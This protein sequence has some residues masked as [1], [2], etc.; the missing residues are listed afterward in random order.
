MSEGENSNERHELGGISCACLRIHEF[1]PMWSKFVY[2]EEYRGGGNIKNCSL[3]VG[4]GGRN[5][6]IDID[7][8]TL[9]ILC[10]K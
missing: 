1:S 5:W 10:I 4:H 2:W 8:Y 7:I 9:L 3:G 6:E